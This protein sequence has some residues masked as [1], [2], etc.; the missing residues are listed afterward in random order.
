MPLFPYFFLLKS[1][2]WDRAEHRLATKCIQQYKPFPLPVG[3]DRLFDVSDVSIIVPTVGFDTSTFSRAL[4]SWLANK[5]REIII[6]T[7]P[8]ELH[9]ATDLVNSKPIQEANVGTELELLTI[10]APN[11]RDQL[12]RGIKACTGGIIALADDDAYWNPRSLIHLLAPFQQSDI[13]IV[14][15]PIE[16][17]LPIERQDPSIITAWAVA[18]L[19]MRSKRRGG[20]KAFYAADGSTNFTV[21]G[22]TM[23]LRAEILKD[24][25]FQFEFAEERFQGVRINT[26]DD[27][28]ITRW[29]LFQHLR[30]DRKGARKWRLGMQITPEAQVTTS[31]IPD[32]RFAEQLKRW[33]RTGLRFRLICLFRDP[34]L[35]SF[36]RETPYMSRKMIE[37][38]CNPFLN[39]LWYA[40]FFLVLRDRPLLGILIALYY[41]HGIVSGILAF[42][43]EFPFTRR[44]IWAAFLVDRVSMLSDWYCW[45]TLGQE[46]WASRRGVDCGEATSSNE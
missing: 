1:F 29:V 46:S 26:G 33:W 16:S 42:S 11:K 45:L 41:L 40:C 20:N 17:Y 7:V 27:S 12:V 5:P 2:L 31:L 39:L 23:L 37:R 22:A 44:K 14:G 18:A 35:R 13:G 10:P 3:K 24:P 15:G 36:R 21:S 43:R 19:R 8:R 32:R 28:F 25:V 6:V 34:G 4:I 38:M 30:E 9:R